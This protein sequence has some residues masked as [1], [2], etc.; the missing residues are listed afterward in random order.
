MTATNPTADVLVVGAGPVG[1]LLAGD[2]AAAGR[3][4][5]LVERRPHG[6]S[7]LTRAFGVHARTL[8]LLDARGLADPLVATGHPLTELRLFRRLSLDLGSLPSRFPFL[9]V[10]PQYEVERLLEQRALEAGVHFRH[11][12]ELT[13]VDQDADGVTARLREAD[14]TATTQRAAYLVGTD[15]HRSSVRQ[16]L[17]MPFPGT[18]VVRS[19]VL[20]DV[21]LAAPPG[22]TLT[23]SGTGHA[24]V[25]VAPFGD[26]WYRLFGWRPEA[27]PRPEQPSAEAPVTLDELRGLAR[28]ALGSDLGIGEARWMSRFHSDERQVP[29]YRTGRVLLAGDAA[30]VHSPA[31]GQ[32][33]NLGLQD[34]ANLSWKLAEVTAGRAGDSLLD[35]YHRERHPVGREVLRS[36]GA[37]IRMAM[38]RT[39][40]H[41]ALRGLLARA[42]SGV[43]PLRRTAVGAVTGVGVRYRA[44]EGAHP[45]VGRRVPDLPLADGGRLYEA[46]R[47]GGFV[48]VTPRPLPGGRPAPAVPW[49]EVPG[50]GGRT[51]LVRPDGHLAWQWPGTPTREDVAAALTR[52][53]R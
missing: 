49:T 43:G 21:R 37:L 2:L 36:S 8:E 28:D 20:A 12:T 41:R 32:G 40:L 42:V 30:H 51:L 33:M 7:N 52:A 53:L 6:V 39:P 24:F 17:G 4:V 45:A 38:A 31:G 15:G 29:A 14:G 10:T 11:H 46:L 34:A 5:T 3:S 50:T 47:T 48:L 9:L 25:F 19:L 26:G 23:V 27:G 18:S 44:P 22:D 35:S 1:L 16:A 13:G